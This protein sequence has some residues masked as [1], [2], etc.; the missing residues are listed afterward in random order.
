MS[1]IVMS[2]D[3]C[4]LGFA[5]NIAGQL[6]VLDARLFFDS[7]DLTHKRMRTTDA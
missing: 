7:L 6:I 4:F 5:S 3:F 2:R 1:P